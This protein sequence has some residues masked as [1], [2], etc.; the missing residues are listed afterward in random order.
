M[1]ILK[2]PSVTQSL[3]ELTVIFLT[4]A[5]GHGFEESNW[6]CLHASKIW[7]DLDRACSLILTLRRV[8][9]QF[10]FD[11]CEIPIWFWACIRKSLLSL[12]ELGILNIKEGG[13]LE[14][15]KNTW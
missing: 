4:P 15:E 13:V 6:R 14:L 3:K 9:I 5:R 11:R 7:T 10:D 2:D 12:D 1:D 8:H